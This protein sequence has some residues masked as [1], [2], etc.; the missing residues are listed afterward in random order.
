MKKKHLKKSISF[1]ILVVLFA[2]TIYLSLEPSFVSAATASDNVVVTLTVDPGISIT[3]PADVT[4]S[5]NISMVNN[6]SV[7]SSSWTVKSN[8]ALGYT[9]SVKASA[10][11]ALV[12]GANSFADYTETVNG[13]PETWST[14]ASSKEFGFSAYNT[15]NPA[16]TPT[17]TWGSAANCGTGGASL[18]TSMKYV[19]FKTTDKIIASSTTVTP[20]TGST[21]VVCYAAEQNSTFAP[22]GA[23]TAN[24]TATAVNL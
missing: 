22:S 6:A 18:T 2:Q 23:Y 24:I 12:S 15:T 4:M 13:T 19:G 11:P 7:G 14:S 1:S 21:T 17:A 5:P 9:L 3:S 20:S 16:E 10:S 8:S